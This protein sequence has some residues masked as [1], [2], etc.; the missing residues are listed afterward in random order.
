VSASGV[1]TLIN[2]Q[3]VSSFFRIL[4]WSNAVNVPGRIGHRLVRYAWDDPV[5]IVH[6]NDAC[7]VE[8]AAYLCQ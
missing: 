5:L 3:Q 8:S 4:K 1:R 7:S 2:N 6:V